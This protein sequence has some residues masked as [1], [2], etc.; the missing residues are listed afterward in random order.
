MLVRAP[1]DETKISPADLR[2]SLA[3]FNRVM[4]SK[5]GRERFANAPPTHFNP[6][7]RLQRVIDRSS[8]SMRWLQA[9][10]APRPLP[11]ATAQQ[12]AAGDMV[13][14]T[15]STVANIIRAQDITF[16][17]A[18]STPNAPTVAA[19]GAG[20]GD[21]PLTANPTHVKISYN[22]PWG[23]GPLSAAGVAT[24]AAGGSLTVSGTPM[25]LVAP[26]TSVN[27]YVETSAGSGVYQLYATT[28]A[29]Y[30]VVFAYGAGQVPPSTTVAMTALAVTQFNFH[31]LFVGNSASFKDPNVAAVAG[32]GQNNLI[33]CYTNGI[34]YADLDQLY[35]W[36]PGDMFAPAGNLT[37]SPTALQSQ[38]LAS[39]GSPSGGPVNYGSNSGLKRL[40]THTAIWGASS[41]NYGNFQVLSVI[42]PRFA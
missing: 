13:C 32:Y 26:A 1:F 37:S 29:G 35:T 16:A 31:Q 42:F 40:A 8:F 11:V 27:V 24:P 7:P 22:F 2:D 23:E 15:S 41:Q 17:S 34:Y 4:Q 18:Y 9:D 39:L 20:T 30:L 21:G 28:T 10:A 36:L 6:S 25:T 5:R 19:G 38:V 12:V 33:L 14:F 3:S